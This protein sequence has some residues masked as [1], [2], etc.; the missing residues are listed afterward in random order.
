M[1]KRT[2]MVRFAF[3]ADWDLYKPLISITIGVWHTAC[4]YVI[5]FYKRRKGQGP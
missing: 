5:D 1:K 4:S 2:F 3:N